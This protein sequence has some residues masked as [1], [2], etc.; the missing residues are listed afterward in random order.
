[1]F[2]ASLLV[3]I[4][5]HCQT[6][7]KVES[8]ASAKKKEVLKVPEG[9]VYCPELTYCSLEDK[10][11][12]TLDLAYPKN[13]VGPYPAVICIHGGGWMR[14][15][16]KKHVPLTLQ[17]A[18]EGFVAL[19]VNYRLIP[20]KAFPAQIHDVK[21][22]VRWLRSNAEKYRVD[23]DRIGAW[24][25]S[26]GGHLACLLGST[27]PEDGLEGE[28][29]FADQSS[30]VQSVVS[31][32]GLTDLAR[33][34]ECCM[35]KAMPAFEGNLMKFV[36]ESFL[37]G[38]PAS[39][40]ELYAKASPITYVGKNSPPTLLIHGTA[41]RKVPFEQSQRYEEK[42]RKQGVKVE[43]MLLPDAPHDFEGEFEARAFKAATEF[44]KKE[45][46]VNG[47]KK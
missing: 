13:G 27:R 18:Q 14:G 7:K 23:K 9:V 10:T 1:M 31:L 44:L 33:L 17:L 8:I 12:L 28:G 24:G 6:D 42:L 43:L 16:C 38:P 3:T 37:G 20:V 40:A 47:G 46:G 39:A 2:S 22:A 21:C 26:S 34:H 11:H 35:Q 19:T 4:P 30:Q 36:L 15:D 45:L 41:D 5:A 25:F 29:G 32:Y